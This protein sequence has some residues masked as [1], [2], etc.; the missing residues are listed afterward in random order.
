LQKPIKVGKVELKNRLMV[1][2]MTMNYCV[3]GQ[4]TDRMIKYYEARAKGG[5]GAIIVEG[6]MVDEN[7]QFSAGAAALWG[8]EY[9]PQHKKLAKAIQQ[10]GCAA[11]IQLNHNGRQLYVA[12][13]DEWKCVGPSPVPSPMLD[14]TPHE[15]TVE[16]IQKVIDDFGD[17]A[18]R[19][20]CS[21]YDG[22]E[23]H[24]AHGYLLAEFMSFYANKRYDEYGGS[25]DNRMR[26][27]LEVI[28][29]IKERCGE[30]FPILF[31]FSVEEFVPG[32]RTTEESK[33][34]AMMLEEA[35]VACIDISSS[36]Y[37]SYD[38]YMPPCGTPYNQ[39]AGFAAEIKKVV[40]IPVAV[41]GHITD[42]RL[43]ESIIRS[44]QAD[45]VDIGRSSIA[46]PDFPN[47]YFE[48]H[49]ETIR[50]CLSCSQGCVC[51]VEAGQPVSCM[52][53]PHC[54]QE[55]TDDLAPAKEAKNV[56]VVGGGPAGIVAAESAAS[57]GHHVT[58]YEKSEKLGGA[59]GAAPIPPMKGQMG[60]LLSWHI[61]EIKK[62]GVEIKVGTEY[63]Q[64]LYNEN[65][66]DK[67]IIA[68]GTK[69]SIP[70][71]P[72]IDG[73]NVV[74]A[75]DI[76]TGKRRIR[77][78]V[79]NPKFSPGYARF[80]QE[81]AEK[82][83][84]IAGGGLVGAETA[85]YLAEQDYKVTIVEMLPQIAIE[86]DWRR[87]MLLMDMLKSKGVK[88]MTNTKIDEIRK[89]GIAIT[90]N[91]VSEVIPC[92]KVVLA[93]GVKTDK[94]LYEQL[95]DKENVT[96]IANEKGLAPADGV[97]AV[98]WGYEAGITA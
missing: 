56:V 64:K 4:V 34:I 91:G 60:N 9:I 1:P 92:D 19:I 42:P 10:H 15:L 13:G 38:H 81:D 5:F 77:E 83:V 20:K 53:N 12:P 46:D 86:E 47:K 68:T 8:D 89:D 25:L 45:I 72:G 79:T 6:A 85:T 24:G 2:A 36:T 50:Q 63:T 97:Q 23:L 75:S 18:Y 57:K 14:V 62:L 87:K 22:V 76:L 43:A 61:A 84:V 40:N 17:S 28:A 35:G 98:R 69:P 90:R 55:Y 71:I 96:F 65:T 66:P 11:F 88:I 32:G 39:L 29:K 58:L 37:E 27:P 80:E 51:L 74:L 26:L 94:T 95:K 30:D 52:T 31:R 49:P 67:L 16:E 44:G 70:P 21:G 73:E 54:G 93:L 78:R 59:F 3:G 48:G 82:N 33:A 41:V 7:V